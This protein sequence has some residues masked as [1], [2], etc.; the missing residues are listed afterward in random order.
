MISYL[1]YGIEYSY[2]SEEYIGISYKCIRN[3][4]FFFSGVPSLMFGKTF[5]YS[6]DLFFASTFTNPVISLKRE[7]GNKVHIEITFYELEELIE[8]AGGEP[9]EVDEED[10]LS[11]LDYRLRE[12]WHIYGLWVDNGYILLK[13]SSD[14]MVWI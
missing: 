14:M 11:A 2:S 13:R 6:H 7:D 9:D 4:P 12:M 3:V 10:A 1:T 5:C 8:D